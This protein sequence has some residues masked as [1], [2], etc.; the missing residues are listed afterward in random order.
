MLLP[1]QQN[2]DEDRYSCGVTKCCE[3]IFLYFYV[4][5][6]PSSYTQIYMIKLNSFLVVKL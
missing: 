3:E 4:V 5:T 1:K 6:G 2:Y